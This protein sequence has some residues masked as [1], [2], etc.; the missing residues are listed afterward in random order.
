MG[1]TMK[2]AVEF[3]LGLVGYPVSHSR[4]PEIFH[5]FFQETGFVGGKYH[6]F[7]IP[8]ADDLGRFITQAKR[9]ELGSALIRQ[10]VDFSAEAPLIGF[11]VTVPYKQMIMPYLDDLS[12]EARAVGAVNTV[13][14][15][16]SQKRLSL[17]GHNTDVVGFA[18]SMETF[19]QNTKKAIS[20]AIILGNGGSAKAVQFTLSTKKIPFQIWQRNAWLNPN[21]A[22][23]S[24]FEDNL[25]ENT[26]IINTTPVGMWPKT[27]DCL[28]LPWN[29]IQSNHRLIDLI[30][31]PAETLLMQKFQSKG[32]YSMNGALM[33]R[34]QAVEAWRLFQ[35]NIHERV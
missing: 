12:A 10:G 23:S 31:N 27:E 19:E 22:Q 25:Q 30:Y 32:A 11:N 5:G 21:T 1:R 13:L 9:G 6:L 34:E 7:E 29:S 18:K 8:N 16:K 20:N 15:K 24:D 2:S 14:L 4:S 28:K 35:Q 33:L 3:Q 17:V 26:L